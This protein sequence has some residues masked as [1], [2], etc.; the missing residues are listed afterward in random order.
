E[1]YLISLRHDPNATPPDDL[2]PVV[3]DLVRKFKQQ[4]VSRPNS[5]VKGRIWQR[6]LA[7]TR[8]QALFSTYSLDRIR[9]DAGAGEVRPPRIVYP[10]TLSA[11]VIAVTLFFASMLIFGGHPPADNL[12]LAGSPQEATKSTEDTQTAAVSTPTPTEDFAEMFAAPVVITSIG[13]VQAGRVSPA[14][15][16]MVYQ[17]EVAENGI[18]VARVE[19][20]E[21]MPAMYY[22]V[23][24]SSLQSPSGGRGETMAMPVISSW[25]ATSASGQDILFI[26][27]HQNPIWFPATKG[28]VVQVHVTS[29]IPGEG[30]NFRLMTRWL[31]PTPITTD[32]PQT[33]AFTPASPFAYYSFRGQPGERLRVQIDGEQ[34]RQ[35]FFFSAERPLVFDVFQG[36]GAM[37]ASPP[38]IP[39]TAGEY[40]IVVGPE[41]IDSSGTYS[42]K[43]EPDTRP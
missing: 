5:A 16:V 20:S 8:N 21:F 33:F 1:Q 15:P 22:S 42:I 40:G 19:T 11:A 12:S 39:A 2:D 24:L 43:L 4:P 32:Q 14:Q 38:L 18:G 37:D 13:S 34:G 27:N 10:V 17:F 23:R 30:G 41:D 29:A 28:D 26:S 35:A 31:P 6:T 9:Q 25:Q 7:A 36:Q 3:A